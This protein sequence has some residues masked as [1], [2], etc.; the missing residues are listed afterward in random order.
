MLKD[1]GSLE[2]SQCR[3]GV[4]GRGPLREQSPSCI[5]NNQ[6]RFVLIKV[7]NEK[8]TGWV[9]RNWQGHL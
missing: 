1:E 9:W 6:E 5:G 7:E 2:N 4:P 8:S 3:V